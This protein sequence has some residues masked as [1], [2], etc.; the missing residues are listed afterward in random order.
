MHIYDNLQ[1][2]VKNPFIFRIAYLLF[3]ISCN[4]YCIIILSMGYKTSFLIPIV[5]FNFISIFNSINHIWNLIDTNDL[6]RASGCDNHIPFIDA[7]IGVILFAIALAY[8]IV[9]KSENF[10]IYEFI[11][12]ILYS[13]VYFGIA[14]WE[15]LCS[16]GMLCICCGGKLMNT[17]EIIEERQKQEI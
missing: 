15:V 2:D 14:A 8:F 11:I 16:L 17:I 3:L 4:I 6:N 13:I 1:D 10:I 5:I 7:I 9:L 12:M